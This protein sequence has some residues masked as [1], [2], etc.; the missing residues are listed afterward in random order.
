MYLYRWHDPE[1]HAVL[2]CAALR[3][4]GRQEIIVDLKNMVKD[5]LLEFHAQNR[6]MKP[7]RILFYRDGVSEGQFREVYYVSWPP[8]PPLVRPCWSR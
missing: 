6:G 4:A 1:Q 7:E 2:C 8:L 3:C 5:L